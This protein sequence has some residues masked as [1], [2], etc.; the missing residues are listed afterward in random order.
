[1]Y[2]LNSSLC[3]EVKNGGLPILG[4]SYRPSS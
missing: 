1:M 3:S 2:W 4:F